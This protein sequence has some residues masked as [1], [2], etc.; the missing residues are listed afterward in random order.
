M[1]IT[2]TK[3]F[4]VN[5][6]NDCPFFKEVEDTSVCMDSFDEPNYDW[7]CT[8]KDADNRGTHLE[9]Y[10]DKNGISIGGAMHRGCICEIP[11]WCP[12]KNKQ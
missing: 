3:T 7:Y 1:E 5:Q 9:K 10:N 11:D 4:K 2:V 12:F 6:C 8:N